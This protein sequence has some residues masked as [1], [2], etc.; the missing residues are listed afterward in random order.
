MPVGPA[1]LDNGLGYGV[2]M[3]VQRRE[4]VIVAVELSFTLGYDFFEQLAS[5]A[6]IVAG[7]EAQNVL[8]RWYL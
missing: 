7:L 6:N 3:Q 5:I 2:A 1:Q 8:R 4:K